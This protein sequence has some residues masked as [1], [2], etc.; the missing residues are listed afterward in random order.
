MAGAHGV[1]ETKE[2]ILALVVIGKFV[3][4]RLKDG[5]Q[6]DDAIA[7]GTALLADGDF[8]ATVMAGVNGI[9]QVPAEVKELDIQ[10]MI[11]IA[12]VIPEIVA[13]LA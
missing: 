12:K 2:A 4:D 1:K 7:L 5:A 8:K 3:V 13:K 6:I 9:D 10:D 11:E